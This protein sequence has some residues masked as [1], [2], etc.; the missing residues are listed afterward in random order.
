MTEA[1]ALRELRP[2]AEQGNA[3]AQNRLG[4]M[5]EKGQGVPQDHAAAVKW[6]RKAAAQGYTVLIE[7]WK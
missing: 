7:C 5:Y 3:G 4:I 1:T 2:L 6:Y